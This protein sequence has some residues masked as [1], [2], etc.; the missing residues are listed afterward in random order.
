MRC[1][2]ILA[3]GCSAGPAAP[4]PEPLPAHVVTELVTASDGL[5]CRV[6]LAWNHE[7]VTQVVLAM[8]G[9][10]TGTSAFVPPE[11]R[12]LVDRRGVAVVTFDKPGVTATFGDRAS[13][14]IDDALFA[15]HTQHTLLDCAEQAVQR[16]DARFGR[17]TC[18]HLRGHSEGALLALFLTERLGTTRI[19]TL[20]LTGVP[21]EPMPELIQR[22]FA[23]MP[24]LREAVARCD[25]S[26]LRNLGI[27]CEYLR[28]AAT[29]PSGR[30]MFER[31]A[32]ARGVVFRIFAGE[33]DVLTPVRF[34]R[35]LD[36]WNRDR[37]HLDLVVH[38]FA[39]GHFG[40]PEARQDLAELMSKLACPRR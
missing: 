16:A 9:T 12:E 31:L 10:G 11:L 35:D 25:W 27:S 18:L 23:N 36:A 20:T 8:G 3:I 24:R 5:S 26:V 32:P 1:L 7:P 34:I 29:L 19:Q 17:E 40:A 6:Y 28:D 14:H 4:A 22:Q 38:Y 21:L 39:G 37:G 30:A 13:V 33:D 2:V 15:R